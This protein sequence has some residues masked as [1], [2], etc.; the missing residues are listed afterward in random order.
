[1]ETFR[2]SDQ[3]LH[4]LGSRIVD[5]VLPPGTVLPKV[6]V[7]SQTHG[8]S[9]TVVREALQGLEAR[10]LVRSTPKVGTK[11]RSHHEWQWWN[12]DVLLWA[13]ESRHG[14]EHLQE[15]TEVRMALEPMA[16][17]LAAERAEEHELRDMQVAFEAM[18]HALGQDLAWSDADYE[19]HRRLIAGAHNLLL[20]SLVQGFRQALVRSRRTTI[21]TLKR[22]AG[23][24]PLE[25]SRRVLH[26]HGNVLSAVLARQPQAAAAA[27]AELLKA[28]EHLIVNSDEPPDSAAPPPR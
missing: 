10:G 6:E 12:H 24:D 18:R 7:F 11:V 21:A 1:M 25:A 3:V 26:Y 8:V 17:A 19:F 20:M 9:R 16:V 28:V 22:E 27:M 5:G 4:Y 2:R 15:L 13:I 23:G 14:R